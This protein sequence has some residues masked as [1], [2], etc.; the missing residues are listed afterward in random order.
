[1]KQDSTI[2]ASDDMSFICVSS[3]ISNIYLIKDNGRQFHH[4]GLW[5]EVM[6]QDYMYCKIK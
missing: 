1:M 2:Q 5:N 6:I 4:I 3:M